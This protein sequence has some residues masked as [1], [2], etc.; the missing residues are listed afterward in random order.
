MITVDFSQFSWYFNFVNTIWLAQ[1]YIHLIEDLKKT[2][3]LKVKHI[4]TWIIFAKLTLYM[5]DLYIFF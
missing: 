4:L 3:T 5:S 2:S 1:L